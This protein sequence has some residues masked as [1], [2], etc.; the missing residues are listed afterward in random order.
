LEPKHDKLTRVLTHRHSN[1]K[2]YLEKPTD[3]SFNILFYYLI[4]NK[5]KI[6]QRKIFLNECW[7]SVRVLK[8][9]C[10]YLFPTKKWF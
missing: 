9:V 6:Q 10:V 1:S 4:F 2:K 5:R 8:C 3:V 7:M